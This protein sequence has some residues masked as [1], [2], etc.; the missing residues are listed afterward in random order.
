[1]AYMENFFT[2]VVEFLRPLCEEV[3][4]LEDPHVAFHILKSFPDLISRYEEIDRKRRLSTQA[5]RFC[6][7]KSSKSS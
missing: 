6:D 5:C 2:E 1:M 4:A 3:A 7:I